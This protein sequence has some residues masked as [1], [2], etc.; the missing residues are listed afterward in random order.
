VPV[1]LPSREG[2]EVRGKFQDKPKNF[3]V[4]SLFQASGIGAL[5]KRLS[6]HPAKW[7]KG[8]F[9]PRANSDFYNTLLWGEGWGEGHSVA[10]IS[11]L[12]SLPSL[13]EEEDFSIKVT[14]PY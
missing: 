13:Q 5:A 7:G 11:T 10:V 2:I 6:P 12:T 8:G 14:Q 3:F 4:F 9:L 1:F